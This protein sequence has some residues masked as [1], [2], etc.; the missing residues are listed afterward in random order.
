[1]I[2]ENGVFK[3]RTQKDYTFSLI[4][5]ELIQ[6]RAHI[7]YTPVPEQALNS[8]LLLGKE[9]PKPNNLSRLS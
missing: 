5:R 3:F 6:N 1:M 7:Q 2:L 4:E 8:R 9:I